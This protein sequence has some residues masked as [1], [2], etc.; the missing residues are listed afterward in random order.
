MIKRQKA[1]DSNIHEAW[2]AFNSLTDTLEK[3]KTKYDIDTW[4]KTADKIM[5]LR[6]HTVEDWEKNSQKQM[7]KSIENL[8]YFQVNLQ[9]GK[10]YRHIILY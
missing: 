8:S 1:V 7:M 2:D 3:E 9:Q 10:M 4:R 6:P 5:K